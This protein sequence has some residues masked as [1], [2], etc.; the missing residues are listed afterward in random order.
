MRHTKGASQTIHLHSCIP[1]FRVSDELTFDH[2]SLAC[3]ISDSVLF[4]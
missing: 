4:T 2:G 3:K 1:Y